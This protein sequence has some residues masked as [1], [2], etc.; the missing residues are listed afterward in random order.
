MELMDEVLPESVTE[1]HA[2]FEGAN[3]PVDSTATAGAEQKQQ[4]QS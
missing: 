3:G 4:R 1:Q 2:L